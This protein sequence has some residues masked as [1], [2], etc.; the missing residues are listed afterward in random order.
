MEFGEHARYVTTDG[1]L[2]EGV[3][4]GRKFVVFRVKISMSD[5]LKEASVAHNFFV[6][7]IVFEESVESLVTYEIYCG[8]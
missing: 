6:V 5:G 1:V 4:F 3:I 2:C 7:T 8:S